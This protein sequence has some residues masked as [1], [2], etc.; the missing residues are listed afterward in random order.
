MK[1]VP[2]HLT[3]ERTL[4]VVEALIALAEDAGLPIAHMAMAFAVTHPGVTAAIIGP[5]TMHQLEDLLAGADVVLDDEIL[6]RI[7]EL[8]PPGTD[9]GLL[10]VAYAP[11]PTKKAGLRWR[12]V[13]DRAAA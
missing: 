4:D 12:P 11:P 10:D 1:W 13:E 9:I 8:A 3:D 5:R 2:K 6:D 7:D